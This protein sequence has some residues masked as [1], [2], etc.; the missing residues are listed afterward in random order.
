MSQYAVLCGKGLNEFEKHT[1][2][3][4]HFASMTLK[5]TKAFKT[6]NIL[7]LWIWK[8]QRH[9]RQS[10]FCPYEFERN[11]GI[12]DSQH[13]APMNL[14]GTKAFKTVNILPLWIWKEQRHSR[15]HP[16]EIWMS[17]C[18]FRPNEFERTKDNKISSK[19]I[20]K[21]KEKQNFV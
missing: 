2:T 1:K 20:W 19:W 11:K 8:E 6:V 14:K 18:C 10:T 15:F 16:K 9:S 21:N 17:H 3:S 13:F 4:Q 7:P 12:Q 5:G